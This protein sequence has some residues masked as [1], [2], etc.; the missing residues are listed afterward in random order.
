MRKR[1]KR[2]KS[3]AE[4]VTADAVGVDEAITKVKALDAAKFDQT[5]ELV[6]HLGI[7]PKQADQM[8]RGSISLPRPTI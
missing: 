6:L 7:D 4:K 2:Y 1:S 8:F 3:A 5:V